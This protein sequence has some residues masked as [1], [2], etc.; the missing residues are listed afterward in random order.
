LSFI[1][2]TL[3]EVARQDEYFQ[4]VHNYEALRAAG[5]VPA[6]VKSQLRTSGHEF[7]LITTP[8]ISIIKRDNLI[9]KITSLSDGSSSWQVNNQFGGQSAKFRI[10]ALHS[11]L[12]A[13]YDGGPSVLV[14]DFS[15]L[16]GEYALTRAANVTSS[17]TYV[18]GTGCTYTA[19]NN[20]ATSS[21]A[22]AG[23]SKSFSPLL[24]I[25]GGYDTIGVWVNGDGKGEI[26]NFQYAQPEYD[27][28]YVTIDFTGWKYFEL[29]LRERDAD[30]Y[31]NY[32]WPY[33][34]PGCYGLH[35]FV[36]PRDDIS[37]FNIYYN[38]IPPGQTVSCQIRPVKA[39]L[40]ESISITN[41]LISINGTTI[42]F[43]VTLQSGEYLEFNSM[44]D[45]K[46]YDGH[47]TLL[48]YV[49][50]S[51]TV[52]TLNAGNNTVIFNGSG[53]SGYNTRANVTMFIDGP[54]IYP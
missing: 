17:M 40:T 32:V 28:H 24:D 22:W 15:G 53:A 9:H 34:Y 6:G 39:L 8:T 11:D 45:C 10:H 4:M 5:S 49:T 35:Y 47:G 54:Q 41:P 51:G 12:T 30:N 29:F 14:T 44:T 19:T 42:T 21:G 18:P 13:A 1:I 46:H 7:H 26:L 23:A 2:T 37:I 43:P 3:P 36:V 31:Y 38:N 48:G 25:S 20:S 50:P 27:D 16:P 52:P 33:G